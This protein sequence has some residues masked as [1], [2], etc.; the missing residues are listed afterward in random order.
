ML[1]TVK[2]FNGTSPQHERVEATKILVDTAADFGVSV[3]AIYSRRRNDAELLA[4]HVAIHR[5][6]NRFPHWSYPEIG[7]AVRHGH[8]MVM[9]ALG[10]S[11]Q[12]KPAILEAV[13]AAA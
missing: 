3:H 7:R 2:V 5:L 1:D 6:H 13:R 4:R 10:R 12:K 8:T 11:R 9:W